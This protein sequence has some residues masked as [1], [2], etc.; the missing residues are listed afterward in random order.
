[1]SRTGW[2]TPREAERMAAT[3]RATMSPRKAG[4]QI[5]V[6][7]LLTDQPVRA[8][9]PGPDDDDLDPEFRHL[10]PSRPGQ[11]S[12]RRDILSAASAPADDDD[13]D[14]SLEH[15]WPPVPGRERQW[16]AARAAADR[17]NTA[18]AARRQ[19]EEDELFASLFG[20]DES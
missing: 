5:E 20:E 1:M 11:T 15:L 16:L 10:W 7:R 13:E 6:L 12:R 14:G 19:A 17:E 4:E 9:A 18:A 8:S 3:F 2:I